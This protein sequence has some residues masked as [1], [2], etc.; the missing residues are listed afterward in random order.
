MFGTQ[1]PRPFAFQAFIDE[2][3]ISDFSVRFGLTFGR[4]GKGRI[5]WQVL[6]Q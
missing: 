4:R 2:S 1:I 5:A 6:L 3:A